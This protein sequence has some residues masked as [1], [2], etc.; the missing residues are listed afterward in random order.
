MGKIEER[1]E[2]QQQKIEREKARLQQLKNR[3]K[4]VERKKDTL[5][6]I[7]IGAV[8]AKKMSGNE[9]IKGTVREWLNESLTSDRDRKLF[10]L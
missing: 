10:D 2:K 4:S 9:K 7:L 5:R 1:I 8:V 3:V 6:K